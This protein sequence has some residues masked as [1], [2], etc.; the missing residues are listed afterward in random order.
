MSEVTAI[1]KF[2]CPACGAEAEW[3]PKKQMLVCPYCGAESPAEINKDGTLVKENDLTWRRCGPFRTATVAGRRRRKQCAAR[4]A[5]PSLF[6]T[7]RGWDSAAI[8]AARPPLISVDDI[9]AP[10]RPNAL[11]PFK[12]SRTK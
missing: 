2:P 6:S 9:K 10:I 5:M 11:L 3:N 4:T 7:R 8:F 1:R 12:V